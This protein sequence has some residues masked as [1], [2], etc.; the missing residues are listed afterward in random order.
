MKLTKTALDGVVILEPN[1]FGDDRGY[2]MESYSRKAYESV[3]LEFDLVQDN[4]SLS[5]KAG[6]VRGL[7]YQEKPMAQTKIVR[8]L[9]GAIYDVAV[10][11]RMGSPTFGMWV[12]V[13]LSSSNKRQLVVP[14]GFAHGICTLVDNTVI[15][16]KVDNYYSKDHDKGVKW[17]DPDL[18]ITWP[19]DNPTLSEKDTYQPMLSAIKDTTFTYGE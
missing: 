14:R 10:D 17:D 3:G 15:M 5:A 8:A 13:I 6:T 4:Q 7:H 2:F 11:I 9:S 19:T 12:G 18:K 1:V 16:Y